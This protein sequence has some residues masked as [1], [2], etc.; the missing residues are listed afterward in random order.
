MMTTKKQNKTKRRR[1]ERE[2]SKHKGESLGT[3][4][5]GVL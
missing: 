4:Q 3:N 5:V 2:G 1:R